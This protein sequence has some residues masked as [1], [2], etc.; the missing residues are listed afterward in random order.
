VRAANPLS[1]RESNG[2]NTRVR[3]R[4]RGVRNRKRSEE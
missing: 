1:Q 4:A 3:V 2:E